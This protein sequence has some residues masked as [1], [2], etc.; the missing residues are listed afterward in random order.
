MS[1][2]S[3]N[4]EHS[5]D[6]LSVRA[7]RQVKNRLWTRVRGNRQLFIGGTV[8][9]IT[10]VIA[11]FAPLLTPYGANATHFTAVLKPPSMAHWLGTDQLGRD[12]L[13]RVMVGARSSM[14]VSVGALFCGLVIGIPVGLVSGFYRGAIDDWVIMR[15]VDA[16]QSFPAL[17]LALVMAAMLGPGTRNS[18]IAIGV[19]YVPVFVRTVRGQVLAELQ[20]EYI[21][22][23]RV[24]GSSDWRLMWRHILPNT[25]TPLVVQGTMAMASGI[26]AEASLSYL[27]LGIQPPTASW[28]TM[29]GDAQ[30]YLSMASWLAIAP[31]LAIAVAV[32]GYNLLGDGLQ[33]WLNPREDA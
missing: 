24:V 4:L 7:R 29:L 32:L 33:K 20:K 19:G 31:G 8:V 21:V 25:L 28:G 13:S 15:I 17:I 27:G 30:G 10:L 16:M 6:R 3:A 12:V 5:T 23:A 18:I 26:V 2:Q 11:I 1:S 14:E 9:A 22:A